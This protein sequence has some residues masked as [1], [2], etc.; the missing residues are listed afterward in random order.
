MLKKFRKNLSLTV[1]ALPAVVFMFIFNYVPLFGLILPFKNYRYD[2]GFWG[3]DWVG[4][5]NFE[6]LFRS[7]DALR[8]TKN[9]ILY[10][11][12]FIFGGMIVSVSIALM[13][14]EMSKR[15]VKVTQTFL[16]LP[17][18]ISWVVVSYAVRAFLDM[19]SGLINTIF[20]AFGKDPILWYNDA[21]YWPYIIVIV[22]IWKGMGYGALVYYAA[23]LATDESLYEVA[24]VDGAGKLKQI[25]YISI[26]S[27]RPMISMMLILNI[28][29]ML[30]SD[31]GL[32]Y[33][34]PLNSALL[35]R[36]TD[37]L[38]T[39][40][41]RALINL[42][43]VGM[44]SAASFYQSVVGFFLVLLANKLVKKVSPEDSLF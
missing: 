44:S 27:I 15:V 40:T 28:G 12:V 11:I 16:L 3:S 37:V 1:L 4:F 5:K 39:Y 17:Y 32:F 24:R 2:K 13:L 29:S 7:S 8:A 36:T 19:D 18:F 10:N 25:W 42:G 21:K 30:S 31:F 34:V 9:T 43:D 33:N 6:Y 22:N 26:P 14:Y 41:Y 38:S 20:A 23:L 35:Y